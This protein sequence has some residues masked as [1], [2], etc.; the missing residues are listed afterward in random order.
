MVDTI[1]LLVAI[2][3]VDEFFFFLALNLHFNQVVFWR[4]LVNFIIERKQKVFTITKSKY[5][6]YNR[7][8]FWQL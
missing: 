7:V 8:S 6:R 4:I 5:G 1:V 3:N 2:V